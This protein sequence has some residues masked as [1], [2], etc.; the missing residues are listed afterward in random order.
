MIHKTINFMRS[1][2]SIASA[3][4]VKELYQIADVADKFMTLNRRDIVEVLYQTVS[5]YTQTC[6]GLTTSSID[7]NP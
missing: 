2:G 4:N 7:Q 1:N 3:M 6:F 5:D